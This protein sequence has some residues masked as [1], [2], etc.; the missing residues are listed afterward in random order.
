M[1]T[2]LAYAMFSSTSI[3]D[4]VAS[5]HFPPKIKGLIRCWRRFHG[6]HYMVTRSKISVPAYA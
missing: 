3:S 5:E 2:F 1:E 4:E 6:A